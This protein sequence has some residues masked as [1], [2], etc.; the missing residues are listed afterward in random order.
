MENL[1][2]AF[3]PFIDDGARSFIDDGINKITT[4]RSPVSPRTSQPT[5]SC[6]RDCLR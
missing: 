5:R 6:A 3:E 1:K 2:V 4:L